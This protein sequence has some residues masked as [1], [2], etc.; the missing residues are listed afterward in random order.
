MSPSV[1]SMSFCS[2]SAHLSALTGHRDVE[3]PCHTELVPEH[4]VKR[5]PTG[6]RERLHDGGPVRET[7][8]VTGDL[9][10]VVAAHRYEDRDD[11][12]V[13]VEVSGHVIGHHSKAGLAGDLPHMI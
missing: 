13:I 12:G 9:G 1:F 4:S 5:R 7:L 8:S 11:S 3:H 10:L 6:N 2:C